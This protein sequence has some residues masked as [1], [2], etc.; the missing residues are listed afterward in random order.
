MQLKKCLKLMIGKKVHL[1]LNF[2]KVRVS[3]QVIRTESLCNISF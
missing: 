3:I 2:L 1:K